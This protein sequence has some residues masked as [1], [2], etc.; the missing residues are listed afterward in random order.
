VAEST[1]FAYQ[2]FLE[3]RI[4]RRADAVIGVS[5]AVLRSYHRIHPEDGRQFLV[6]NG[7]DDALLK[8]RDNAQAEA[9]RR[10]FGLE[11]G[12]PLLL[13][14]ARLIGQKNLS[15][16]IKVFAALRK[17][18]PKAQYWIAGTGPDEE[19]LRR[20]AG[21]LELGDSVRFLGYRQDVPDLLQAADLYM[22]P[23][24]FEGLPLVLVEAMGAGCIPVV[25][26]FAAAREMVRPG[27]NGVTIPYEDVE[28]GAAVISKLLAGGAQSI[29][30]IRLRTTALANRRFA[31]SVMTRRV[32]DVYTKVLGG[33][34]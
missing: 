12:E 24:L 30:I 16:G 17:R 3:R 32:E 13:S 28:D 29:D 26:P 4:Y 21:E 14:A 34:P 1:D 27:W 25:T 5:R 23:S 22:M 8:G 31:A 33:R 2:N 18:Q 19:S 6:H 10:E 7:V 15:H 20:L 9:I 11:A